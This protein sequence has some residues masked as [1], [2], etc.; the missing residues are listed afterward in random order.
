MSAPG[1]TTITGDVVAWRRDRLAR[2]GFPLPL[3]A[4]VA[5]DRRYDLHALLE[6]AGRGCPPALAV[7]ILTPLDDRDAA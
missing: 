4:R 7:R 6:L 2:A 5:G 3:A 1:D